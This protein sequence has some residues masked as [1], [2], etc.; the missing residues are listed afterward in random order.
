MQ[1]DTFGQHF[2]GNDDVYVILLTFGIV[3]IEVSLDDGHHFIAIATFDGNCARIAVLLQSIQQIVGSLFTLREND[4]FALVVL[5][6]VKK[7]VVQIFK[8]HV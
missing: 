8:E 4:Q 5:C 1:V 2:S 7:L 6:F 3:G